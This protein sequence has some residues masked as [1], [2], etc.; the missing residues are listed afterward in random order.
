M[1]STD[2]ELERLPHDGR[3]EDQPE[4]ESERDQLIKQVRDEVAEKKTETANAGSNAT[5]ETVRK[6]WKE[7]EDILKELSEV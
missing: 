5:V 1:I 4:Y 3:E 2:E 7:M 6:R